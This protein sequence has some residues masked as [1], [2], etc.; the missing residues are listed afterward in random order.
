MINRNVI[1]YSLISVISIGCGLDKK[2]CKDLTYVEDYRNVCELGIVL[3][4]IVDPISTKSD[5]G[6][7]IWLTNHECNEFKKTKADCDNLPL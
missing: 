3:L 6:K 5:Y 2:S 4:L 1:F 7:L